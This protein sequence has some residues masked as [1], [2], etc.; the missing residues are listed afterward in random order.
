[1]GLVPQKELRTGDVGYIISGIKQ[2]NEVK[3]GDT[4]TSTEIHVRTQLWGLK[5]LNLWYLQEYILWIQRI[6]RSYAIQW[7][8][9]I[10]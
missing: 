4:I 5:M 8:A 9:S 6:M 10:E 1:M 2:A 7:K 3:V